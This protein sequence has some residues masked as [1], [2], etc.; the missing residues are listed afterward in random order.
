MAVTPTIYVKTIS[1]NNLSWSSSAAG[2]P[3]GFRLSHESQSVQAYTGDDEYSRCTF[4]VDKVV[5]I[6]INLI[7]VKNTLEPGVMSNMT[8][9]LSTKSGTLTITIPDVIFEGLNSSQPRAM[10]GESELSFI[11][12]VS[13]GQ[14]NPVDASLA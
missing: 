12:Q 3:L 4:S 14:T 11:V 7:E 5:R 8:V 2:G 9:T 10:T 1:W 13:D 6:F